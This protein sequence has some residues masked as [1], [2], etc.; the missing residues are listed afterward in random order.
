MKDRAAVALLIALLAA[1]S[2]QAA[3]SPPEVI[4][5]VSDDSYPPYL[6]RAESGH[7]E[8]I[9][10]DK[11]ALWSR[12]TG[13]RVSVV[14]LEWVKAQETVQDGTADVIDALAYTQ[15]RASLYEFSPSY[16]DVDARV[17][18]Q[19]SITG[20]NNDVASMRGFIIG[21]KDGSACATWLSE[22]GIT[23]L[24]VYPTSDAVVEAARNRQVPLFCMDVP[25]AQYFIFKQDLTGAFH[26]TEPLYKARFHWAVAKGHTELRDFI[27]K[28]FDRISAAELKDIDT[29]WI[30]TPV[31]SP[32]DTRY[33]YYAA[34]FALGLIA[35]AALLAAWNRSLSRRVS[36]R[37]AELRI[38]LDS[39]QE[40]MDALKESEERFGQMFRLSPDG[41][42]VTTVAEGRVIEANDAM[43]RILGRERNDVIGRT[44]TA[45]GI[46]RDLFEHK[47]M[48]ALPAM[49]PGGIRQY[50]HQVR[51]PDG[52]KRDLLARTTRIEL[53]GE[54]VLLSMVRDITQRRRAQRLLEESEKRLAKMIEGSP[55]AITIASIDDGTFV[56]V[57]PAAER[58]SG[59]TRDEMIGKSAIG[60]GFWPEPEERKRLVT[61]VQRHEA[62]HAR[63]IRLRRKDGRIRDVLSS[64]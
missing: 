6:F 39:M 54:A 30:G 42:M 63:E 38:A 23:T 24:R 9:I 46:W 28:G 60:L 26:Q 56:L 7:L 51:T 3:F 58:L 61:D 47:A 62:V 29:R 40:Q 53:Q 12:T 4:V 5:V 8:G 14:G 16:A 33:L 27:Q 35:T 20:I 17:Y 36:A 13:V 50:E 21:A 59:Y 37:T 45:L 10:A 22:R 41:I 15:A 1:G 48:V 11:W 31:G 49:T 64:A 18:F 34:A 2:A 52:E 57:N 32:F 43:L 19:K 44:V 55:E 25:A